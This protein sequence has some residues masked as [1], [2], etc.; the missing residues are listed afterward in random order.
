M[1]DYTLYSYF[2]SSC[3]ARLRIAMNLKAIPYE[4]VP[5]NLLKNEHLSDEHK[6]FNPSASVPVLIPKGSTS[7]KIGQSVAAL[8]Y[9]DERHPETPLLP[10]LSDL[11]ARS[12][13]RTLVEIVAADTQPVTNL[14]ITRRIKALGGNPEEWNCQLMTDG[15][16][17]Y[18][19]V[20]AKSAGK[21]SVG[22]DISM[23]DCCL[24]PA[25][26]NAERYGVDLSQFPVVGR[27]VENL[28]GHPAVVQ[29]AYFNQPDTPE[30]LRAK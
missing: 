20:A 3:S 17:A 13:V 18:E 8:E 11:E 6:T 21:Y 4:T 28:K 30:E 12:L 23:A 22:D 10:P 16:R 14:R 26:W 5:V 7:F 29:A 24:M 19:T 9:L 27:I 25:F 15:M 2:R 1:S